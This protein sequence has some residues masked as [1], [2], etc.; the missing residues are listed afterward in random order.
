M[1]K[2]LLTI[3]LATASLAAFAQGKVQVQN[4]SGSL[5][6][7]GSRMLPGDGA[8]AGQATPDSGPLP[9]GVVLELGLYGG[10]TAGVLT[11]QGE[12]LLNP[13]GGT[14]APTGQGPAFHVVTSYPAYSAGSAAFFQVFVWDSKY[15]SPQLAMLAG[16]YEGNN[17]V[18]SMTPGTSIAYPAINN[19]GGTTW[20]SAGDETPLIVQVVPEPGTFA[21][22][23]LASAA[24]LIFRRRK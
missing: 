2:T 15:S 11:L 16:S 1:K 3:A 22:A 8:F 19:G 20:A 10:A 5:Y 4:D 14:A 13:S 12:E 7:F 17:N 23:G 6:M 9:S 21:L 24:L 18:F